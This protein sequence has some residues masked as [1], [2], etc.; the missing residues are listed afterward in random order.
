MKFWLYAAEKVPQWESSD[1]SSLYDADE[2]QKD[3][4]RRKAKQIVVIDTTDL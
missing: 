4:W 2:Y 3:S 1:F